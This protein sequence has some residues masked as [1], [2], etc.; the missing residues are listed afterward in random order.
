MK[1]STKLWLLL[2]SFISSGTILIMACAGGD[3]DDG[4]SSMFTPEIISNESYKPFFRSTYTPFY[5]D[6]KYLTNQNTNF[7]S[8]NIKEWREYFNDKVTNASL[9]FWLYN[10]NLS[11]IDA[12]LLT[13]QKKDANLDD[14]A[15]YYSL[16]QT[17]SQDQAKAFLFYLGYAKR[18]E[19]F[20]LNDLDNWSGEN[21]AKKQADYLIATQIEGGLKLLSY[22]KN[23]FIKER[24]LF[25]LTRLY[26]FNQQYDEAISFYKKNQAQFTSGNSMKWRTMGYAAAGY[27][28]QKNYSNANYLYALIYDGFDLQKRS[29]YLSFRPQEDADW[30]T[31]LA[32]AKTTHE[33]IVLWQL[34]GLYFDA[35]HAMKEMYALD[36]TSELLELLLVRSVNMEEEKF[37]YQMIVNYESKPATTSDAKINTE[38]VKLVSDIA[39]ERKTS[40]P[41]VWNIAA[42]YLNYALKEYTNGDMF[43]NLAE[44][45]K[46]KTQLYTLQFQLVSLFGKL[47]RN[48]TINTRLEQTI[49]PEIQVLFDPS[50]SSINSFRYSFAQRWT[51]NTLAVLYARK[52]EFE[53]AEMIQPG[54]INNRFYIIANVQKMIAYYESNRHTPLE[55][56]FL[57]IAPRTKDDYIDLLAIRYAQHDQL[58]SALL[59]LK[60]TKSIPKELYGN[61]FTIHI[62]DCHDCD[63]EAKQTTKYSNVS[64]IEKM[65]E[66]KNKAQVNTKDAA[67]NYF[68]LAN[69]FYN[70]SYFGNARLFYD[71]NISPFYMY[72]YYSIDDSQA[73][74]NDNSLALKYYLLAKDNSTDKEFKAKCTFM[75]AKCEQN[76][77]LMNKPKDYI[78]DFKSGTYFAML[79]NEYSSTK[80][81]AE[82]IKECGYFA[83]YAN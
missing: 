8:I 23:N 22:S 83:K 20:T 73:P 34:F 52:K 54:T 5:G 70:M 53:K 75:A 65:I 51:R 56:Y 27:Y 24:Y 79:K 32:L 18:N 43:L 36:P 58:D 39:T 60:K 12:M 26:Y 3:G 78:G 4:D 31:C 13:L 45:E 1:N 81:F 68:L 67:Q 40:N 30:N 17:I 61:P 33:K 50:I 41:A 7:N 59:T 46:T 14:S 29:A 44:K 63:H 47:S 76:F 72:F 82:I 48:Q 69:G 19:A 37:T 15:K 71:N 16:A 25:Q 28:K 38:L 66:L 11:E 64:F 62:N 35:P 2:I 77:W 57:G 9:N 80:Y 6:D 55:T 42:A 74:E 10:S 21:K 49:L